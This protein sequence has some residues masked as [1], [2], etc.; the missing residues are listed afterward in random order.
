MFRPLLVAELFP[1]TRRKRGTRCLLI[2]KHATLVNLKYI[3]YT[4]A[5]IMIIVSSP[6]AG[7]ML[8]DLNQETVVCIKYIFF[9]E[10]FCKKFDSMMP[11]ARFSIKYH[12]E[13]N[14]LTILLAEQ[15][16]KSSVHYGVY[17]WLV[18]FVFALS[19]NFLC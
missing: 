1:V 14:C 10:L 15:G 18:I 16:T 4:T 17:F 3:K 8:F 7:K 6:V 12:V 11:I 9:R 13:Q 19:K 5:A 2:N